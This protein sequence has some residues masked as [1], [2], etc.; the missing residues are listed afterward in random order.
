VD[1]TGLA[2]RL[3]LSAAQ[4]VAKLSGAVAGAPISFAPS[5][6]EIGEE[7][8]AVLDD[9]AATLKRC[10]VRKIEI[11]GHTDAQGRESTNLLL[12]QTRADAVLDALLARGVSL[13]KL[14]AKGYG[15][16]T[17]VADNGSEAGRARNRRI[18]FTVAEDAQ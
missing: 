14:V 16:S 13:E 12:S 17:P 3:P 8:A 2:A 7:S 10:V 1:Q 15:E 11:G 4:C 18:E 6:A 5:S 9:L